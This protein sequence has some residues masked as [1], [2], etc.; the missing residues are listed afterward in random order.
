M[1]E[2]TEDNLSEPNFSEVHAPC[3]DGPPEAGSVTPP[4]NPFSFPRESLSFSPLMSPLL[5]TMNDI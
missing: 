3:P 1:S 2:R 4:K 5:G